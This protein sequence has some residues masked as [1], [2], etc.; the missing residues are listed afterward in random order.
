VKINCI[1]IDDEPLARKGIAEYVADVDYLELKGQGENAAAAD[2]LLNKGNIDLIF[3][4]I[5]MP[6]VTGIEFLKGLKKPPMVIFTTAY[7]EY[8]L[9][10]YEL[11]VLDYLVKPISSERFLK[12]C[13]KAKDFYTLKQSGKQAL[14]K[15]E[16]YFFIRCDDRFEKILYDELLYIEAMENYV[17]FHTLKEKYIS[18][19][20]LKSVES[21]LPIDK[22][23]KVHKSFIVAIP[24]IESIDGSDILIKGKSI[25]ISR[26]LKEEVMDK[27]INGRFLKR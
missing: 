21:Y 6:K 3:L 27:L 24:K 20:T 10:G 1:I 18:Y 16:D 22:F 11:D 12:A 26:I 8:A 13:S 15:T 14:L 4:D 7:S 9:Q 19:L 2:D 17:I 5:Q 25:P 23:L